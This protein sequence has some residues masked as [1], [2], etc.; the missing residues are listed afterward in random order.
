VLKTG[1]KLVKHAIQNRE[2]GQSWGESFREAAPHAGYT[3]LKDLHPDEEPARPQ[4]GQ[5]K[6]RRQFGSGSLIRQRVY[7]RQRLIDVDV[8]GRPTHYNF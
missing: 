8:D 7:K 1:K 5:G 6:R 2:S 4:T 3:V